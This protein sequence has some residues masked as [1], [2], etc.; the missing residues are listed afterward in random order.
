MARSNT[1]EKVA[2]SA[3]VRGRW[4]GKQ[5]KAC[6]PRKSEPNWG[7]RK[8]VATFDRLSFSPFF[9]GVPWEVK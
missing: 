8:S 5:T 3:H 9:I 2:K 6:V 4:M 1:G 7:G